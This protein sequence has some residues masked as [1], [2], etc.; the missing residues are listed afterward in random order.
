[1]M[2]MLQNNILFKNMSK[3]E[4]EVCIKCSQSKT[5]EFVKDE[6][7]FEQTDVPSALYV[8]IKG[9]IIVCKD[10]IEG[11]RYIATHIHEN[12]IF[13]EVFVFLD[14]VTYTYYGIA[15]SDS[16]VLEIPKEFFYITCN[17]SCAGH[18]TLINNLLRIL[19]Q[20]AYFL[21]NKV[22]LLTSGTLRQKIAKL[23]LESCNKDKVIKLNMNREQLADYLNVAR[24]SLSRELINMQKD[25]LIEVD[26]DVIRILDYKRLQ[27]QI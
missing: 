25:L 15:T 24:P 3:E 16:V 9:S 21:N 10:S 23:V 2:D 5:R 13:G 7:I 14:N 27:D 19:A 6:M 18:H 17:N 26:Q 8:L 11:K 4:I 1:M 12:D 20:K 22:Q